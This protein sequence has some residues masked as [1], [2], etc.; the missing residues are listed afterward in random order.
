LS[1]HQAELI[2]QW[3]D[4]LTFFTAGC[5]PL[6]AQQ[7]DRLRA[8]G[9]ELVETPVVQV[10][11]DRGQLTGVRLAD[12][13]EVGLDAI[14]VGST[15]RPHDEFLASMD[16]E[17]S[18]SPMGTNIRV[19]PTGMTSHPRIW[20]VG[21]VVNPAA[22][23]PLSIGAGAMTGGAVNMALVSEDF[24]QAVASEG[25]AAQYWEEQYAGKGQRWSGRVNATMAD[26]AS[27]LPVGDALDLGCGEG[28]DAVWLAEQGWKVT[29]VDISATA[30]ARGVEG[31]NARGVAE[32]IT[33][34]NHD[35]STV[36]LP[37]TEILRRAAGRVRPGGHL[38]VVSHVFESVEDIPPWALRFHAEAG[39]DDA[40]LQAHTDVLLTPEAEFAELDLDE[41]EWESVIQETRTREATG[42]DRQETA[43]VK[44]GVLLVRR[45]N[46]Q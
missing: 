12:G 33:W 25:E 21:N 2:R 9:I 20:A 40:D 17:R 44:D 29:A 45:R 35:L 37:R 43:T 46:N 7:A 38:L 36:E 32:A 39:P 3:S 4:R 22:N 19:D 42:P 5:G 8:R 24:D 13:Q 18:E 27:S 11:E 14:F 31:A 34:V 30:I 10:L 41:S 26:V 6:S 23:V 15:P 1:L 28:G 16:L